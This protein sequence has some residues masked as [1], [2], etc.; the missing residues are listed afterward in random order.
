MRQKTGESR[1]E[2]E[3]RVHLTVQAR[4]GAGASKK[5]LKGYLVGVICYIQVVNRVRIIPRLS[6]RDRGR[7][8]KKW[9]LISSL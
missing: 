1:W 8:Q 9:V 7:C 2:L 4:F 5:G 3:S 6:Y